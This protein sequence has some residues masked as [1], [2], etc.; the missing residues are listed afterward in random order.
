MYLHWPNHLPLL[1]SLIDE[2][3]IGTF[4]FDS[5]SLSFERDLKNFLSSDIREIEQLWET[6]R[7]G[8]DLLYSRYVQPYAKSSGELVSDWMAI[9]L[10]DWKEKCKGNGHQ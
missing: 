3:K 1:D 10:R 9:F 8:R 4:F 7:S 5:R 2:F 6:K